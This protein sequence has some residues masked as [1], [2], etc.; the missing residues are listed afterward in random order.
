MQI[1]NQSQM[2]CKVN[3]TKLTITQKC[4]KDSK[5]HITYLIKGIK[6][7]LL[8]TAYFQNCTL[9]IRYSKGHP[10]RNYFRQVIHLRVYKLPEEIT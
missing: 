3:S 9:R 4:T 1:I 6:I 5:K 8:V 2:F 10:K 7:K